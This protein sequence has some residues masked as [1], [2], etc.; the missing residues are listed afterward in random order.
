MISPASLH[1]EDLPCKKT[2]KGM[3]TCTLLFWSS[4]GGKSSSRAML[5]RL[6][7]IKNLPNLG[8]GLGEH[9]PTAPLPCWF[10]LFW[11]MG[12][13]L[14]PSALS[15]ALI[16]LQADQR[17]SIQLLPTHSQAWGSFHTIPLPAGPERS[18]V[19]AILLPSPDLC[20]AGLEKMR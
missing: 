11:G 1:L 10:S 6:H 12:R 8:N 4:P 3:N 5:P 14:Y 13:R 20:H 16:K 2:F 18:R 17:N 7:K 9:C 15:T 19:A